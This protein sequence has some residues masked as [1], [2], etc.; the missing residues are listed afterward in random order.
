MESF[1]KI[2][3][4]YGSEFNLKINGQTKFRSVIGG[5]MSIITMAVFIWTVMSF[6]RDFYL[7][8]NPKITVGDGIYTDEK[9]PILHGSDYQEK[10]VIIQYEREF[11]KIIRPFISYQV[12]SS[13]TEF[14]YIPQCSLDLLTNKSII[15]GPDDYSYQMFTYYCLR[16]ND[17][18]IGGISSSPINQNNYPLLVTWDQCENISQDDLVK[19]NITSCDKSFNSTLSSI[20][21]VIW[22]EKIGFSPNSKIP[23]IKKQSYSNYYLFNDK[24]N[25]VYFPINVYELQDDIGWISNNIDGVKLV[26]FG[27]L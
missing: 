22:Y 18:S 5:F 25:F 27:L 13:T 3:D 24:T 6:G 23:F 14:M 20:S 1:F 17:Y 15:S 19:Y 26:V 8:E 21:M 11:D 2:F 12:N 4:I 9:I 16:M 10:F 7:R